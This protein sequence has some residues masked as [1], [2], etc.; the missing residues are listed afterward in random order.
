VERWGP[1]YLPP[2]GLGQGVEIWTVWPTL[3]YLSDWTD[4]RDGSGKNNKWLKRALDCWTTHA[5]YAALLDSFHES[6]QDASSDNAQNWIGLA[7][8]LQNL[9]VK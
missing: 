5:T 8:V 9:G 2:D 4:G 3:Q 7:G 1:N 6:A